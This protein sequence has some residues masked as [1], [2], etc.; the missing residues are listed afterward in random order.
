MYTPNGFETH[1]RAY[2]DNDPSDVRLYAASVFGDSRFFEPI[3]VQVES[4]PMA[5]AKGPLFA[6]SAALKPAE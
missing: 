1:V 4:E 3:H 5:Q 2:P 6:E